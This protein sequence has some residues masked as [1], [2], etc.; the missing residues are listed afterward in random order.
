[1]NVP[2]IVTIN[3]SYL[4]S[5]FSWRLSPDEPDRDRADVLP[6]GLQ[7]SEHRLSALEISLGD[8]LAR[9]HHANAEQNSCILVEI[10]IIRIFHSLPVFELER[11]S[12][13]DLEPS[14]WPDVDVPADKV[15]AVLSQLLYAG[16]LTTDL[17]R[18]AV[19][20]LGLPLWPLEDQLSVDVVR[21]EVGN[22]RDL[23]Q[24]V[25]GGE[26][27]FVLAVCLI[28]V[29]RKIKCNFNKGEWVS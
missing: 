25:S 19:D 14:V 11:D 29:N 28:T 18:L 10:P 27:R 22:V 17:S 7:E 8:Q 4:Q 15:D 12:W 2:N 26:E 23:G 3:Q 13:R 9:H 16:H 20:K 1:M 6:H 21:E 24:V 5:A